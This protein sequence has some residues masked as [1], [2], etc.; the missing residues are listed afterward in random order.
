M[1]A[2]SLAMMVVGCGKKEEEE[3]SVGEQVCEALREC[4]PASFREEWG[5]VR[6]CASYFDDYIEYATEDYGRACGRRYTE[7]LE[8]AASAYSRT[9]ESEAIYNRCSDEMQDFYDA[10]G[11]EVG[12]EYGYDYDYYYYE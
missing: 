11:F 2:G 5:G 1:A 9:C 3:L 4:D 12:Y 7:F 10:C 6:Q 8:C